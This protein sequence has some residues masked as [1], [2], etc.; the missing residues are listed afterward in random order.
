MWFLIT[1]LFI[2]FVAGL[3]ARAL[4][5][6][7]SPTG[8]IGTTVLGVVGSLVGGF[9]GRVI[10]DKDPGSG[11]F[12]TSGFIG[13]LVGAIIVLLVYRRVAAGSR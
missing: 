4:V 9:L 7:P 11:L 13:S 12:Q 10:F 2:G 3:L 6:G 8:L 1:F 5:S